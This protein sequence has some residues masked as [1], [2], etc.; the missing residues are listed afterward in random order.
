MTTSAGLL[1]FVGSIIALL[2]CFLLLRILQED[3][4][5]TGYWPPDPKT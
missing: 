2:V 5:N 1:W 4:E 3:G